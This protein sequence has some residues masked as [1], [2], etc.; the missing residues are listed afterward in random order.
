M[1]E[2]VDAYQRYCRIRG[3][4]NALH[5]Y[6]GLLSPPTDTLC[7]FFILLCYRLKIELQHSVSTSESISREQED[8]EV[9]WKSFLGLCPLGLTLEQNPVSSVQ[10]I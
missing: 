1:H 5:L 10:F 7:S 2:K 4:H 8:W 3:T 9:K 6:A